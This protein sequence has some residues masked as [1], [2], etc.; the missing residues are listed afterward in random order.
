MPLTYAS[1][2][3]QEFLDT[4][5]T[6]GGNRVY[7]NNSGISNYNSADHFYFQHQFLY[8]LI[9]SWHHLKFKILNMTKLIF[10][11]QPYT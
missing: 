1:F 6:R 3:F 7:T 4:S 5:N 9:S 11:I 2:S 8:T 10:I